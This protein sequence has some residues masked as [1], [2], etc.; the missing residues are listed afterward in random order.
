MM[1]SALRVSGFMRSNRSPRLVLLLVLAL[2]GLRVVGLPLVSSEAT[3]VKPLTLALNCCVPAITPNAAVVCA[4]PFAS[5]TALAG[6]T[7]PLPEDAA[8][9]TVTPDFRFPFASATRTFSAVDRVWPA[10]AV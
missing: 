8:K 6:F 1:G 2:L 5:V 7:L 10:S 4:S 9:F 3:V